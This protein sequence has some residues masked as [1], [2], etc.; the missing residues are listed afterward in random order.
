V[1]P[2]ARK[3][4]ISLT[5]GFALSPVGVEKVS[6]ED[7]LSQALCA[8]VARFSSRRLLSGRGQDRSRALAE[9]AHQ[10][11]DVLGHRGQE[12][13]LPH[14]LQS[15]QPQATQSDLI[16]EFREQ[17]FQFL[18]LPLCLRELG[19][20]RQLPRTLPGGFLLVDD[21]AAEGGTGALWSLR[22]RTTAFAGPDIGIGPVA[23]TPT[24]IV[25]RLARGTDVAIVFGLIRKTLRAIERAVLSMDTVA[26]S[27][28]PPAILALVLAIGR[29]E[30]SCL[31][32]R[33]SPG[34][35]VPPSPALP[36]SHSCH[37][38][39][40]S[41]RSNRGEPASRPWWPMWNR[42]RCS[43][44]ALADAPAL[45]PSSALPIPPD[46]CRTVRLTCAASPNCYLSLAAWAST[47]LPSTD[48][49]LPCTN[50]TS[51]HCRTVRSNSC[52]NSFDS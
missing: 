19:R 5:E 21:Q 2:A 29:S 31:V 1:N 15:A 43:I 42:D 27:C 7:V 22:A 41:C 46:Y 13:L 32:P 49:C 3:V 48:R 44:P 52:S 38:P 50:P 51:T 40:G 23:M 25:K 10:S 47:K 37:C 8:V 33:Q 36:R 28:R 14:Q 6:L 35:S 12:E 30:Q 16:L 17:G 26:G 4:A 9:E 11:L 34:S 20:V 24:A 45:P 39:P 18:S